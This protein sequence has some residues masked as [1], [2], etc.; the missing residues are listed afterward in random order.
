MTKLV[1]LTPSVIPGA[2][3]RT[4]SGVVFDIFPDMTDKVPRL[5]VAS[6]APAWVVLSN[7]TTPKRSSDSNC[8]IA[9]IVAVFTRSSLVLY[10]G[11]GCD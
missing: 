3:N 6:I 7:E 11:C 10:C 2:E 8:I 4:D 1:P 5:T 9:L